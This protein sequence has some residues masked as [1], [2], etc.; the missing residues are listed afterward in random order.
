MRTMKTFYKVLQWSLDALS[1]GKHPTHD[2]EGVAFSPMH[3]PHMYAV[4]DKLLTDEGLVG[5]FSEMRGDWKYLHESLMLLE[6]YNT[7][8]VCHLCRAHSHIGRNLWTDFSQQANH[9]R[10]LATNTQWMRMMLGA[11]IVSPLL[12]IPGFHCWRVFFDIMHTADLGIFQWIVPST[13]W[14]LTENEAGVFEGNDRNKIIVRV[15]PGL[16]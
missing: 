1:L 16:L 7:N 6:Y 3:H 12:L 9:R 11:L 5:C 2:H 13:L 10:T 4:R 14:E 8:Y 15:L